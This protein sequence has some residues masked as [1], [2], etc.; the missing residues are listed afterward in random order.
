ME[1]DYYS[2]ISA[3]KKLPNKRMENINVRKSKRED[4]KNCML[5]LIN[6]WPWL[7]FINPDL[8]AVPAAISFSYSWFYNICVMGN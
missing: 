6:C 4:D 2:E 5:N 3:K 7:D 8:S 1:D